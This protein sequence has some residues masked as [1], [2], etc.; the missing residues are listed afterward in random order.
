MTNVYT[1]Q[2]GLLLNNLMKFYKNDNNI[3][4]IL[5][6]INGQSSISLRLIDWFVT[7]YSKK[8]FVVLHNNNNKRFNVYIDYK[9]R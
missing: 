1:T 7:N 9:L 6:I 4:R 8:H 5:P 2:N 3:E